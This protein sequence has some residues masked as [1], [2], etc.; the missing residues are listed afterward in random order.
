MRNPNGCRVVLLLIP[1]LFLFAVGALTLVLE[2]ISSS[3]L[4]N[5]T[6]RNIHT[7]AF[8]ITLYGPTSAGSNDFTN[9]DVTLRFVQAPV[10]AI[11]GVCVISYIVSG[12]AVFGIWDLR[13]IEGTASHQRMWSW[14]ILVSNF[15]MVGSSAGVLGYASSVQS[16]EKAWQNYEDVVKDDQ[17]FT[18]ETWSCQIDKFY[19]DQ[20]W[21]GPAC[22][23]AKA[24]RILLIAMI[25]ASLLVIVSLWVLIRERGGFKWLSGGKGRYGGFASV[26]EMQ[27]TT[28][29]APYMP[30][31]VQQWSPQP[32]Q[33][34]VGHPNQQYQQWM[35]QPIAYNVQPG[36]VADQ[37]TV[38]K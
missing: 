4:L 3:L 18:K 29:S 20:N 19:P 16:N 13:R 32:A 2:R 21:A 25:V 37:R 1:S 6:G 12:L 28:P 30:Q 31:P 10:Y 17:V 5:Q 8:E 35:P 38:F 27:P 22:G 9:T 15:I 14:I 23:T 34:W 7:G 11:L 33:P 24:T 26:Y 36:A